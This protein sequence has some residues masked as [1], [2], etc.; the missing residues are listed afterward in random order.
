MLELPLYCPEFLAPSIHS[1]MCR[2]V[3]MRAITLKLIIVA[4]GQAVRY[5]SRRNP[6]VYKYRSS[7]NT[8]LLGKG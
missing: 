3:E 7:E 2:S 8:P 1:L 5:M 6:L 4:V